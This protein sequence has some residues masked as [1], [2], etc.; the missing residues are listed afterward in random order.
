MQKPF[1]LAIIVSILS[2]ILLV[3]YF[4]TIGS[5]L[6]EKQ[7]ETLFE[8]IKNPEKEV[9]TRNPGKYALMAANVDEKKNL[10]YFFYLPFAAEAWRKIGFEPIV[11]LI[12]SHETSL[13]G[14]N[15]NNPPAIR[16]IEYL[17]DMGATLKLIKSDKNY[18][19]VTAMLC[20][21]FVGVIDELMDEDYV[22]TSDSDLI[23]VGS[24]Y[25]RIEDMEAITAWNAFCCG[26]FDFKKRTFQMYPMGHI[27]MKKKHWRG[28]MKL[29]PLTK[30]NT[31]SIAKLL[32]E[33]YDASYVKEDNKVGRGDGTWNADQR[34]YE[35]ARFDRSE[36]DKSL[37]FLVENE[38]NRIS[39]F[40]G[41]HSDF[42][43][44]WEV[45]DLLFKRIFT[46]TVYE[47]L[48]IFYKQFKESLPIK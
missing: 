3:Y 22:L 16:T 31:Q 4:D 8:T 14:F 13:N 37:R 30:I 15:N 46:Y 5:I 9:V 27:G 33:S 17:K 40:H 34:A 38:F 24:N 44:R 48:T 19:L 45:S 41:F 18:G 10:F 1:Y 47:N 7:P 2:I 26:N 39:D 36:K 43:E 35:G 42:M 12:S 21:L 29:N 11:L 25:Y 23:P 32:T 28:V 6:K 20:R